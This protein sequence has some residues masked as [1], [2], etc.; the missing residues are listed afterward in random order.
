MAIFVLRG[1]ASE[2]S[3]AKRGYYTLVVL[4]TVFENL[5]L[6]RYAMGGHITRSRRDEFQNRFACKFQ[7]DKKEPSAKFTLSVDHHLMIASWAIIN[8]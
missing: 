2:L 7:F 6:V 1:Q 8:Q 5:I 3:W 4:S